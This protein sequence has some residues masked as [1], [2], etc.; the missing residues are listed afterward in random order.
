M[1][2]LTLCLLAL[3]CPWFAT[4]A[5]VPAEA[6]FT[7]EEKQQIQQF[8]Q[9]QTSEKELYDQYHPGSTP[10]PPPQRLPEKVLKKGAVLPVSYFSRAEFPPEALTRKLRK[11]ADCLTLLIGATMIRVQAN[12]Q[13]I[14]DWIHISP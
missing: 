10:T 5:P 8:F 9:Q 6:A 2:Y 14:I 12:T 13:V 11:P 3:F 7:A 1:R 4:A